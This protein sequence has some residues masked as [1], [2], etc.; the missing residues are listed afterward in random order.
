MLNIK[1]FLSL[2]LMAFLVVS[3]SVAQDSGG[4]TSD[5][6]T[7]RQVRPDLTGFKTVYGS[8]GLEM[9]KKTLK[10]IGEAVAQG[11]TGDE[12]YAALEY[13]SLEGLKNNVMERGR[14]QNNYPEIREL[15]AEQLGRMGTAKAADLLI[16]LCNAEQKEEYYVLQKAIKEL[17]DIGINEND[18]TVK[19][20][21]WKVRVYNPRS[22][23]SSIERVIISAITA[24]DKL[25]QKNG[26]IKN[27]EDFRELQTFLDRVSK[28][29]FS[30]PVQE[31]AK[32]VLEEVLRRDAE[33]RQES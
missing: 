6:G 23:D 3:A 21:L 16:Q 15:A 1:R 26:G 31:Y 18:K 9:R 4:R 12:I 22:P 17:G 32:K 11:N 25:E 7:Q 24:L 13:M 10:D 19:I 28:G 30:R 27:Q 29:H 14:L 5:G 8:D 33:R 20:I 2:T